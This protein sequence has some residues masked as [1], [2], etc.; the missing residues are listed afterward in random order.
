MKPIKAI[1]VDDEPRA[2]NVLKLLLERLDSSIQVV[3]SCGAVPEAISAIK[4][5]KPDVVF[6]DV[7]MHDYKGYEIINF[8]DEINFE[9]IFVTAYDKYAIRA[10][11]MG[12]MD[13]L[14][15]PIERA[16]LKESIERLQN[17]N[18]YKIKIEEYERLQKSLE[19]NIQDKIVIPESGNRRVVELNK[20]IGIEAD[21]SYSKIYIEEEQEIVVG[22]NLTYFEKLIGENTTFIRSH[23]S[24]LINSKYVKGYNKTKLELRLGQNLVAKVSRSRLDEFRKF[25]R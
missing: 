7:H 13:Y 14:V 19:Q 18:S 23:R 22:K 11:E 4:S 1:I 25:V 5:N 24:W 15:K 20:I 3:A 17:R 21:G 12:A 8:L 10:F 6:L 16:R 2:R 9:I